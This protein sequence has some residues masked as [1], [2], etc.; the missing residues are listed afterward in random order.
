MDFFFEKG[1]EI[2]AGIVG[3]GERERELA[4]C[5]SCVSL[6]GRCRRNGEDMYMCVLRAGSRFFGM[7]LYR[8]IIVGCYELRERFFFGA[9]LGSWE[10]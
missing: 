10:M 9:A 5:C 6:R 8:V 4:F 3:L 7:Q 1:R 2:D